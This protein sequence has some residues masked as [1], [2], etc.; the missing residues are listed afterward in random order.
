MNVSDYSQFEKADFLEDAFFR[1]WVFRPTPESE[2]FWQEWTTAAYPSLAAFHAAKLELQTMRSI[3]PVSFSKELQAKIWQRI[4]SDIAQPK[5]GIIRLHWRK[6]AVAASTLLLISTAAYW[7]FQ[8]PKASTTSELADL[9]PHNH[10]TLTLANGTVI[11]LNKAQDTL[12]SGNAGVRIIGDT[13]LITYTMPSSNTTPVFN[14]LSVPRGDQFAVLLADGTKIWLNAASRLRYPDHFSGSKSRE[15]YLENGEAYFQ[16]AKNANQP[17]IVHSKGQEILVTGTAFNLNT[18][19]NILK[20]T[21][22]EGAVN[23]NANNNTVKLH[24]G[25]QAQFDISA[26]R[27]T[28]DIVNVT[29]YIAWIDGWMYMDESSLQQ[30]MEQVSRWYDLDI[31][32]TD[33]TLK[34]EKLGGKLQKQPKVTELLAILE[35]SSPVSFVLKNNTI[36]ISRK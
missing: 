3:V 6:L 29:P 16:I 17:F 11:T 36:Y 20:T 14:T 7:L 33:A 34:D 5:P 2:Q 28:V 21:L 19:E 35:K 1:E 8:H 18:Y 12:N 31:V 26:G 32:F 30:V 4:S 24:P 27:L 23:V 15:V 25:E 10:S 9:K 22:T 13:N